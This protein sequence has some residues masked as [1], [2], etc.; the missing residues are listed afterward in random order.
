M[1][2]YVLDKASEKVR[3]ELSLWCIEV[4][5]GVFIGNL[6]KLVREKIWD[7][8]WTEPNHNGSLM[9]WSTNTEQGFDIDMIGLPGRRLVDL[10]GLKMILK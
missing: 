1:V 10:D 7:L 3:G 9:I 6:S 2:V 8:I 4:K 5:P